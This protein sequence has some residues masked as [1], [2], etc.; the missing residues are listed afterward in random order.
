MN[1]RIKSIIS[2]LLAAIF[3]SLP[4]LQNADAVYY[5]GS[6]PCIYIHGFLGKDIIADR[7]DPSS[8]TVFP[9]DSE[10]IKE[11]V[12][13]CVPA[14][15]RFLVDRN[16]KK[17]K[18]TIV[19]PVYELLS[20][21]FLDESGEASD[22]SGVYF[23]YPDAAFIGR[24]SKLSFAYDWRLDPV[25]IAAQL[26]DFI[27]YVL[28]ASGASQ[29][30]IECHSF[31]GTVTEAYSTIYGLD[32]IKSVC[33]NTSA[34]FGE[35]YT[36]EMMSGNF[37]ID[38]DAITTYVKGMLKGN[39][40]EETIANL[41]DFL[42][43][44]GVTDDL[45]HILNRVIEKIGYDLIKEVLLPM[46]GCWP[47]V[48]AM[49]PDKYAESAY[50]NMVNKM[51]AADGKDHSK[52]ISKIDRFNSE[53][54]PYKEEVLRRQNEVSNVYVISRYG[55]TAVPLT[56]EW[57]IMTDS[58]VDSALSSFGGTFADY[59]EKLGPDILN[60]PD[61]K[62]S[63]NPDGT[64][65]SGT[66]LFPEQTWFIRD[67]QHSLHP[68]GLSDLIAILLS[69][70]EQLTVDSLE[71]YPR[72]LEYDGDEALNPDK[73]TPEEELSTGTKLL[74]GFIAFLGFFRN[75]FDFIRGG[76]IW[77]KR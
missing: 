35:T 34:V 24:S 47:S 18:E 58:V 15:L 50:D 59:G 5:T 21:S 63:I 77:V 45:S 27:N 39:E 19:P 71:E 12:T 26:N 65:Y 1:S 11:T 4:L 55:F 68:D 69:S 31:G 38:P 51:F 30:C 70:D 29:V 64:V 67:L 49:I 20:P 25:D 62:E 54:R 53:I 43:A 28:A 10:K 7:N 66:C 13:E 48:W 22:G 56:K 8:E 36:G 14:L 46:F 3:I 41:L 2:V 6:C 72:F 44:V 73:G 9:P 37:Y 75:V 23:Q 57:R 60:N 17:L 74:K 42:N 32:K 33:Y 61:A 76:F 40:N 16:Y 52:L